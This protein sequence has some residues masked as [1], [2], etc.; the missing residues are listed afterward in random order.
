MTVPGE[1][2]WRYKP[3]P[4]SDE[5][6]VCLDG[7]ALWIAGEGPFDLKA[8]DRAF[9]E[10]RAFG[11]SRMLRLDL[12][13]GDEHCSVG[14]NG[15]RRGYADNPNAQQHRAAVVA[16]LRALAAVRPDVQVTLGPSRGPS[17]IMFGIGLVSFS[18][19]VA[20]GGGA[21][22]GGRIAGAA[23][24]VVLLVLVGAALVI[25]NWPLAKRRKVE[26]AELADEI[27]PFGNGPGAA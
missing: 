11:D 16:I 12:I 1:T 2:R 14:F 17:L 6:E 7:T 10:H 23:I 27:A 15:G 21:L 20:I 5:R 9:L 24:P 4:L 22:A 18:A 26:A 3:A 19:G 13:R 8:V 25:G